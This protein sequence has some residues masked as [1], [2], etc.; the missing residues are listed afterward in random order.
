MRRF[1]DGETEKR[2]NEGE[3]KTIREEKTERERE[4]E[5]ER[6]LDKG[7]R[8]DDENAVKQNVSLGAISSRGAELRNAIKIA[9]F[10]SSPLFERIRKR[11]GHDTSFG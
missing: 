9:S 1:R 5:R 7:G 8:E 10:H 2:K 3:D 11:A 6:E 4:R